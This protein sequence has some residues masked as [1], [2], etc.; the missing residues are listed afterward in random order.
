[1]VKMREHSL[2]LGEHLDRTIRMGFYC[3]YVPDP[4]ACPTHGRLR[5]GSR[6]RALAA[7]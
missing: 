2:P 3:A 5:R 4:R 7:A 6:E 1:M